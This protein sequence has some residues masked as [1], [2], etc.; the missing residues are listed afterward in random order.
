MGYVWIGKRGG[1]EKSGEESE[2]VVKNA[3]SRLCL[4]KRRGKIT[5][6]IKENLRSFLFIVLYSS[7]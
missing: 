7:V 6:K 5:R 3:K 4:V 2:E 1:R